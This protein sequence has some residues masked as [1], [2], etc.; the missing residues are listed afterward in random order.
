MTTIVSAFIDIHNNR[1]WKEGKR[2]T[3]R[4]TE[5]YLKFGKK[6]L[7]INSPKIIFLDKETIDRLGES[8]IKSLT[9]T[10]II[11]FEKDNLLLYGLDQSK[12]TLPDPPPYE[13]K[14]SVEYLA[15]QINKTEWVRKAIEL[16]PFGT[17]QFVWIDFGI[18]HI[19]N[20]ATVFSKSIEQSVARTYPNVRMAGIRPIH[21]NISPSSL[22]PTSPIFDLPMWYFAGGVFGGHKDS[23][24][25]FAD[26][27]RNKVREFIT[28]GRL[29]WEINIWYALY[30]QNKELFDIYYCDHNK[31]ILENY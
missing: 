31:S 15:L 11:P 22:N 8:Y 20:D 24:L 1:G 10:T 27:V 25:L 19:F 9:K 5:D 23:L 12:V 28:A 13:T 21:P 7:E 3:S 29:T 17:E 6:I 14:P 4:P 30:F 26:R 18:Y 2:A 16:N